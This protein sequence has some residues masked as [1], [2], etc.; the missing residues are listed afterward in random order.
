[1]KKVLVITLCITAFFSCRKAEIAKLRNKFSGTWEKERIFGFDFANVLP[2]GN[3]DIIF[4][5]EN[6]FFEKRK[7][8]TII[9]KGVY[10][11]KE[12]KD[13]YSDMKV[14]FFSTNEPSSSSYRINL[15]GDKLTIST[16]NCYADGG[17][18]V[19]RKK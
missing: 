10:F 1:M 3:G 8:D 4:L 19:Y 2:P 12:R 9:F 18:A 11:L 7:N 14:V 15:E 16:T 13:C 5:G 6:G 17:G